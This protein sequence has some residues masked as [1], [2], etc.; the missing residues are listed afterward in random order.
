MGW[1]TRYAVTTLFPSHGELRGVHM[2][3]LRPFLIQFHREAPLIMRI[4]LLLS[5]FVF[6]ITPILTVY[7]PLPVFLLPKSL[8]DKHANKIATSNIYLVRQ[9]GLLIKMIGGMC[10][11]QD[12][13]IRKHFHMAPLKADPGT[14]RDSE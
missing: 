1:F 8:R 9:T 7:V 6:T 2:D 12:P 5:V 14:W 3:Q 11:G 10:W 13:V 4:G